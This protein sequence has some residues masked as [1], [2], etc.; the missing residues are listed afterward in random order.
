MLKDTL[1]GDVRSDLVCVVRT[2]GVGTP[3]H[4]WRGAVVTT[5]LRLVH[6]LV[7]NSLKSSVQ[8]LLVIRGIRLVRGAYVVPVHLGGRW[9]QL[10]D[11]SSNLALEHFGPVAISRHR[12]FH[13]GALCHLP[14]E[15]C[16]THGFLKTQLLCRVK[17]VNGADR[18][19]SC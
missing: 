19:L 11:G 4:R 17:N 8:H 2:H 13:V 6:R 5:K 1:P 7:T 9:E 16:R 10:T 14:F 3:R 12:G 18:L 15:R